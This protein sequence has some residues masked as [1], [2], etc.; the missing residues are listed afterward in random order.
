M[1][2][3]QIVAA[4][5]RTGFPL[6]YRTA[7]TFRKHGW[8]TI[9]NKYYLDD[10]SGEA[11]EID[12]LAYKTRQIEDL[13]FYSAIIVSCKKKNENAWALVTK[14]AN[15]DNKNVNWYPIH[16]WT[17]DRALR[18][19][20]EQPSF[21][22]EL[23]SRLQRV[24]PTAWRHPQRTIFAFQELAEQAVPQRKNPTGSLSSTSGETT[25]KAMNDTAIFSALSSLMKAQ[26]YEVGRL[27]DRKAAKAAY[28]FT[29]LSVHDGD[30]FDVRYEK[31]P[32]EVVPCVFHEHIAHYIIARDEQFSRINF[33]NS[34]ALDEIVSELDK[35]HKAAGDEVK[36]KWTGFYSDIITDKN[37]LGVFLEDF[38]KRI[39]PFLKRRLPG[40]NGFESGDID[41]EFN[42]KLKSLN[43]TLAGLYSD[44]ELQEINDDEGIG[45]I[46]ANYLKKYFRYEGE[47][48]FA[49]EEL[50]F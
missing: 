26:A 35:A 41:F 47:F 38:R 23:V 34:S 22:R 30:M 49:L 10:R 40:H 18:Y 3:D 33:V 42:T 32:I 25:V 44:A 6:E 45:R 43:I 36:D 50:P 12:L 46:A 28:I 15:L 13:L 7:E 4:L 11:R 16:T 39:F 17:N 48:Q 31:S 1:K 8:A 5:E 21:G 20:L 19:Q 27:K 9:A 24:A 37:R 2:S 14:P 29:L